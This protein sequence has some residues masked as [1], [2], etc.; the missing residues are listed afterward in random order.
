VLL[1][2]QTLERNEWVRAIDAAPG[3]AADN[4]DERGVALDSRS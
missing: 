4:S 2:W 3:D 1:V